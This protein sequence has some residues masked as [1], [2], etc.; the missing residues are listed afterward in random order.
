MNTSIWKAKISAKESGS[1]VR[2]TSK[3]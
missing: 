2:M 1:G 3:M